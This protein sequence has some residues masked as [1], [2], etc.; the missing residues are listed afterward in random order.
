MPSPKYILIFPDYR[1]TIIASSLK[2]IISH[3]HFLQIISKS[4]PIHLQFISKIYQ[5][6]LQIFSKT[7]P[8]VLQTFLQNISKRS[9]LHTMSFPN[10]HLLEVTLIKSFLQKINFTMSNKENIPTLNDSIAGCNDNRIS[11]TRLNP[12]FRTITHNTSPSITQYQQTWRV[13]SRSSTTDWEETV[14]EWYAVDYEVNNNRFWLKIYDFS[15]NHIS[16]I[17]GVLDE[18]EASVV[19]HGVEDFIE[20]EIMH[21]TNSQGYAVIL[22][23]PRLYHSGICSEILDLSW[24]SPGSPNVWYN[25]GEAS[26]NNFHMFTQDWNPW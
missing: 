11:R 12:F 24:S 14:L 8:N 17:V 1:Q 26:S 18:S 23:G 16:N 6:L 19:F 2:K 3:Q 22:M 25:A 20:H 13:R 4:S 21:I 9:H 7:Y 10:F 15:I 5:H